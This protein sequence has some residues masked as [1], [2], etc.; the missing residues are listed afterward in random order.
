MELK[1]DIKFWNSNSGLPTS[2]YPLKVLV[3]IKCDHVI[4]VTQVILLLISDKTEDMRSISEDS[5][6]TF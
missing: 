4:T 6:L 5:Y 2:S 1:F 3:L